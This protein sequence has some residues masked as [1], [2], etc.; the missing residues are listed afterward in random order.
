MSL[1]KISEIGNLIRNAVIFNFQNKPG[2]RMSADSLLSLVD[3]FFA[4]L[5]ERQINYVLVGGVAL[6]TYV[7]GRNTEDLDLI[8]PMST[9]GQLPEIEMISQDIYF[10]RGHFGQLKIDIF[11]TRNPLF[12]KVSTHYCTIQR[13]IER[14]IR[15]A[16]VEGLLLLKLYALP[17]LYRQGDFVQVGLYEND[18]ATLLYIYRSDTVPL[19]RE[20][21]NHLDEPDMQELRR[22]VAEIHSKID[23]FNQS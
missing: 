20:L 17:S 6:L 12:K 5:E 9:L 4:M 23:H 7:E 8:L 2:D 13:F 1:R 14:D 19:F 21:S 10:G 22:I 15:C 18:I 3:R 11:F 16:T